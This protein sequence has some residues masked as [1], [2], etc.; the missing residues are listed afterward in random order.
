MS[1][2]L[3]RLVPPGAELQ[4][5]ATGFAFTEGPIWRKDE[6]TLDFSDIPGDTRHRW[7]AATGVSVVRRPNDKGN[8]MTLDNDGN[9]LVCE[10]ATSRVMRERPDGRREIVASH[11]QGRE[12]NSP[13]DVVITRDGSIYFTDPWYGRMP[14]F[15]VERPRELDVQGVYRVD[16]RSGELSQVA[17]DFEMPNGLC[18]TADEKQ[19]LVNDSARAHIRV[20]DVAP[21]GALENGRVFFEGIGS[22]AEGEAGVD[23]MKLDER[24]NVYV[25]G[26]G[27]IWVI[28][29]DGEHLGTIPVPETVGNLNW[30]GPDWRTLYICASTSVYA[31]EMAVAGNRVGYMG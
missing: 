19:L 31:L 29:P 30:G 27:G 24:G 5:L 7:S 20:F 13:N 2:S 23:G 3:E 15:G 10:H 14:V 12:L 25:T 21:D 4:R 18:L 22:G 16:P 28:S 9:L 1:D 6:G 26:P 17:D 8:G 11:W